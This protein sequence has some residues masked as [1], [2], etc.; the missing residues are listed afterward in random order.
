MNIRQILWYKV[1]W[2][3]PVFKICLQIVVINAI[4]SLSLVH[5]PNSWLN[6]I[7]PGNYGYLEKEKDLELGPSDSDDTGSSSIG[8]DG[9]L[10]EEPPAR[11]DQLQRA[12]RDDR[13][14]IASDEEQLPS[15][16]NP[17]AQSAKWREA[18]KKL[19]RL[20]VKKQSC[21][22]SQGTPEMRWFSGKL[23]EVALPLMHIFLAFVNT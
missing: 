10:D 12:R 18:Q 19:A 4:Q 8:R 21:P 1:I 7:V 23:G 14:Q 5:T 15:T 2:Y 16:L 9:Q 3:N 6:W 22:S 11:E 20:L 17:W 13:L